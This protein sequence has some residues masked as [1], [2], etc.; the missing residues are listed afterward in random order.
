MST[1]Y[2]SRTFAPN[3]I[4]MALLIIISLAISLQALRNGFL[5][6]PDVT[7]KGLWLQLPLLFVGASTLGWLIG[8][9]SV[10]LLGSALE[11]FA[12][13]LLLFVSI[14]GI[15]G[16][17]KSKPSD[18]IFPLAAP[19]AVRLQWAVDLFLASF[20]IGI[21]SWNGFWLGLFVFLFTLIFS[22]VSERISKGELA[23]HPYFRPHLIGS[24]ILAGVAIFEIITTIK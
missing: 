1:H 19:F 9:L 10:Y 11:V 14:K 24:M 21:L 22:G 12:M 13:P 23:S 15:W 7:I 6:K 16:A 3:F 17:L 4:K 20:V 5:P 2:F 18:L 8:R